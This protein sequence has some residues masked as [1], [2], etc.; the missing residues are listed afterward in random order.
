VVSKGGER[1][2]KAYHCW[3]YFRWGAYDPDRRYPLPLGDWEG[4]W[5]Q[6]GLNCEDSCWCG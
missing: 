4:D 3:V 6:A 2:V 5:G 1:G